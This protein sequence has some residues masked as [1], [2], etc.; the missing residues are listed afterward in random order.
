[1]RSLCTDFVRS[2]IPPQIVRRNEGDYIGRQVFRPER[3]FRGLRIGICRRINAAAD[4]PKQQQ[5]RREPQRLPGRECQW[6]FEL[7]LVVVGGYDILKS[8]SPTTDRR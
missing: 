5:R 6:K 3:N 1:M 2:E 7:R 4:Q 8:A